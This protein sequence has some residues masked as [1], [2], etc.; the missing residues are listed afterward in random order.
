[1]E[2]SGMPMGLATAPVKIQTLMNVTRFDCIG[3]LM[4]IYLHYLREY[5]DYI[6]KQLIHLQTILS[7]LL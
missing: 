5:S 7:R 6:D 4:S 2:F 3:N 1:M